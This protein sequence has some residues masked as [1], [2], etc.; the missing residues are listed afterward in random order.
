LVLLLLLLVI[1]LKLLLLLLL[2]VSELRVYP[3]LLVLV[4]AQPMPLLL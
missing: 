4:K 1:P 2:E 3:S